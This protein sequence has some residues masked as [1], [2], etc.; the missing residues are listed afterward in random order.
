MKETKAYQVNYLLTMSRLP[1]HFFAMVNGLKG[2]DAQYQNPG[3]SLRSFIVGKALRREV[4][5]VDGEMITAVHE[6]EEFSM[7]ASVIA[8]IVEL[9]LTEANDLVTTISTLAPELQKKF[10]KMVTELS[11]CSQ[12]AKM[13]FEAFI[14]N[15]DPASD[16]VE[17]ISMQGINLKEA[18]FD[19]HEVIQRTNDWLSHTPTNS[20][21]AVA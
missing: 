18:L 9:L 4:I 10:I 8:K 13:A 15:Q 16:R 20:P 2:R 5:Q 14:L 17:I 7:S 1:D 12:V 19:L 11:E 6:C 3:V 21:K